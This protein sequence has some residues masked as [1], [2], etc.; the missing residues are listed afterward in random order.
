MNIFTDFQDLMNRSESAW[1]SGSESGTESGAE[2]GGESGR[3]VN[4]LTDFQ[5]LFG[6]HGVRHGV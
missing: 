2:S 5:G 1:V 3:G 4:I 6:R